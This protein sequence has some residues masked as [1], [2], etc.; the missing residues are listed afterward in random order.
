MSNNLKVKLVKDTL[1]FRSTKHTHEKMVL[2]EFYN[3][4]DILWK[5]EEFGFS[6]D[7]KLICQILSSI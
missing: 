5:D 6:A 3:K 1:S 7:D 2:V 4:F